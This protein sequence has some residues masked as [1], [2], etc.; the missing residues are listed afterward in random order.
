MQG[1]AQ[2]ASGGD[3][4]DAQRDAARHAQPALQLRARQRTYA[5]GEHGHGGQQARIGIA[6]ARA[7]LDAVEQGA[8]GGQDGPQ[9][10]AQQDDGGHQQGRRR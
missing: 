9:V 5:H 4:G 3:D 2:R 10:Q 6:E 7:G 8:D 1:P